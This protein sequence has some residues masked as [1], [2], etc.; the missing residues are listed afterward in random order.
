[1]DNFK[2]HKYNPPVP[3]SIPMLILAVHRPLYIHIS[4]EVQ[5][6]DMVLIIYT[7]VYVERPPLHSFEGLNYTTAIMSVPSY[8]LE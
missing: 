1:M 4:E 6:D 7:Y 3:H 8:T 5:S 2:T